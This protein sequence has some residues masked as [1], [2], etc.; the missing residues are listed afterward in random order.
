MGRSDSAVLP[1]PEPRVQATEAPGHASLWLRPYPADSQHLTGGTSVT[2][3][4][5]FPPS[6]CGGCMRCGPCPKWLEGGQEPGSFW[7]WSGACGSGGPPK[8]MWKQ[9]EGKAEGSGGGVVSTVRVTG[10]SFF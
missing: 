5:A 1:A 3:A 10:G 8:G 6:W 2:T 4:V 7:A 9:P